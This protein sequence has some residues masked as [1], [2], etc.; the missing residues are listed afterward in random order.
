MQCEVAPRRARVVVIGVAGVADSLVTDLV[1]DGFDASRRSMTIDL[2][3][4]GDTDD[5]APDAIVLDLREQVPTTE[6]LRAHLARWS[7]RSTV[8]AVVP[9]EQP[10]ATDRARA[11]G[12]T[13]VLVDDDAGRDH[14]PRLVRAAL[15]RNGSHLGALLGSLAELRAQA[16]RDADELHLAQV[17]LHALVDAASL[18]GALLLRRPTDGT[19]ALE[20]VASAGVFAGTSPDTTIALPA[21]DDVPA[22]GVAISASS[23]VLRSGEQRHELAAPI[24]LIGV[25]GTELAGVL[26]KVTEQGLPEAELVDL[27]RSVTALLDQELARARAEVAL[28]ERVKELDALRQVQVA[29]QQ[30]PP[31]SE[32]RFR[33]AAALVSGMRYRRAAR[34]ELVLDGERTVAGVDGHLQVSI[35]VDVEV[36]GVVRGELCVGYVEALPLAEPEEVN[37]LDAIAETLASYLSREA[38]RASLAAAE[39]RQRRVLDG[40]PTGV[41]TI[42]PDGMAHLVSVGDMVPRRY[43]RTR[44]RFSLDAWDDPVAGWLRSASNR[45][46]AGERVHEQV[47]WRGR[48]WDVRVEPLRAG[49][50]R[51]EEV[52]C[53]ADDITVAHR[54][55]ELEARLAS[56]VETAHLGIVSLDLDG[57]ITSWN[58]GAARLFGWEASE[59]VGR[60]VG[61]LD[62][63]DADE[64]MLWT[65]REGGAP[66]DEPY[67]ETKRRHRD[68]H[69]VEVGVSLAT[70]TDDQ[71]VALGAS[72]IYHDLSERNQ[73]RRAREASEQQFQV[74][75]D[76]AQDVVYRYQL[77]PVR[78][79]EY[80]SPSVETVFGHPPS[81]FFESPDLFET[82]IHPADRRRVAMTAEAAVDGARARVRFRHADG[83]WRWLEDQRTVTTVQGRPVAVTGIAR[84]V[85]DEQ[86][87]AE[88]MRVALERERSAA[89][90]LRRVDDMKSAFLSAVSHELRTPLTSV[91]GFAE[92]A[93]RLV[94]TGQSG[95]EVSQLLDRLVG[96]A[97][98]LEVL[99]SDL[100]DVDRLAKGDVEPRRAQTDL[101]ELIRRAMNRN[102]SPEHE[103]VTDLAEMVVH[104]D[105]MM[106]DR[107]IDNLLRNAVRHTPAGTTVW[108]RATH[109]T[110][111]VVVVVEDDGPGVPKELHRR[112]FEPFQQGPVAQ[113]DASPGTGIGLSL[114]QRFVEVHGGAVAVSDR[115]GGGA[116]FRL[117]IPVADGLG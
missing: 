79:L 83:R 103:F 31:R 12:A 2:D 37:L 8:V 91:I 34:A 67:M 43:A 64:P 10:A 65:G 87:S 84:D 44:R 23:M 73:A 115:E 100:L 62:P 102:D 18:P 92:T 28:R 42:A 69:D 39:E 101:R 86:R 90:Q 24:L 112:I 61:M 80:I 107:A 51:I 11:L 46:L 76:H 22:P 25:S 56:L 68:G 63:D 19:H 82:L 113:D 32:L 3:A 45:A 35:G 71:G 108:V 59:A 95:P 9:A 54:A 85:T 70:I 105:P 89:A 104:I 93:V 50:G 26:V 27:A 117:R 33:V 114:V 36:D 29:V 20:V 81:S 60:G 72:A 5:G 74:L 58:R 75:A 48:R 47:A 17:G 52:L 110:A 98:R 30:R 99:V 1:Q 77:A 78:A 116:C 21:V 97:R 14:L 6:P 4:D 40:L 88:A 55:H 106:I 96:N 57:T 111:E 38:A 53:L 41:L 66:I 94:G 15:P 49:D 16:V 13:T 109:D 7:D